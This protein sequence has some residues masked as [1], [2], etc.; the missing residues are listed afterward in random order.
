MFFTNYERK[1][2]ILQLFKKLH[3]ALKRAIEF[4]FSLL[5]TTLILDHTWAYYVIFIQKFHH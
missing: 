5:L 4:A 1:T 3:K 2:N